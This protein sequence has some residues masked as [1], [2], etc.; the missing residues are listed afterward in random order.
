MGP[1][2]S[3]RRGADRHRSVI[4]VPVL[5]AAAAAVLLLA[6][7][8]ALPAAD[9][10]PN[11]A[12]E[13]GRARDDLRRLQYDL[14]FE[15]AQLSPDAAIRIEERIARLER[16]IRELTSRVE[17]LVHQQNESD[18]VRNDLEFRLSQIERGRGVAPRPPVERRPAPPP[19]RIEPEDEPEPPREGRRGDDSETL[20]T[21]PASKTEF[22]QA[23]ALVRRSDFRGAEASLVQFL[24]RHPN[25]PLVPTALYWL[26]ESYFA[27]NRMQEASFQFADVVR[28]F[29]THAK[30]QDSMFKLALTFTRQSKNQEAC[31]TFTEYRRRYPTGAMR[32][33]A[34]TES[35]R[36]GCG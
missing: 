1:E 25:D 24:R 29:P 22:D 19:S 34:E 11:L 18:R 23:M 3:R 4:V 36:L 13:L 20:R 8:P 6:L 10:A 30:A 5:R 17:D 15:L 2:P 27:Q 31:A 7:T 21:A 14:D 9:P 26:G 33:E 12:I 28:K 35:K 32:R 16:T